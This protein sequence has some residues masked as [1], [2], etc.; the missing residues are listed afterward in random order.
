M[1]KEA[2]IYEWCGGGHPAHVVL[3]IVSILLFYSE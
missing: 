3:C 2:D 1:A